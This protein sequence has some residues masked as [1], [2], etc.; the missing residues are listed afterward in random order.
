MKESTAYIILLIGIIVIALIPI[1]PYPEKITK[2]RIDSVVIKRK[3]EEIPEIIRECWTSCGIMGEGD[4]NVGDSI[5][6]KTII[7]K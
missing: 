1:H 3:Y 2:C 4:Y 6:I 7:L 5:Q